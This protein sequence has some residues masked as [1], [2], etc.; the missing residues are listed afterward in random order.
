ME[1]YFDNSSPQRESPEEIYVFSPSGQIFLLK[2]QTVLYRI[3]Q[4]YRSD[5]SILYHKDLTERQRQILH[6]F[7]SLPFKHVF[8]S[9]MSVAAKLNIDKRHLCRELNQILKRLLNNF[10]LETPVFNADRTKAKP[11]D[12]R[13][14]FIPLVNDMRLIRRFTSSERNLIRLLVER[15]SNAYK[16]S[17]ADIAEILNIE[18]AK[19]AGRVTHL[20]RKATTLEGKYFSESG[21]PIIKKH[22]ALLVNLKKYGKGILLNLNLS[23]RDY[24]IICT[25]MT[26]DRFGRYPSYKRLADLYGC[27]IWV[28]RELTLDVFDKLTAILEA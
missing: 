7:L 11:S 5:N 19:I 10:E 26:P 17:Y 27:T 24:Q 20:S 3:I 2:P 18:K 15:E 9:L 16:Y 28:I 22:H 23:T 25:L 4:I 12:S 1:G 6:S 13:K 21:T 14:K 8:P